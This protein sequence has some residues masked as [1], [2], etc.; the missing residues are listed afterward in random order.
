MTVTDNRRRRR[1]CTDGIDTLWNIEQLSFCDVPGAVRGTCDLRAAPVLVSSLPVVGPT[2]SASAASLTFASQA[3]TTTS[4]T[5][6]ITLTNTGTANLVVS[7][8][9][10]TGTD[11]A[12]F[13]VA[14]TTCA[15]IVINASCG[16]DVT[17]TPATIGAKTASLSI[18]SNAVGSPLIV[19]LTGTGAAAAPIA[20]V[21]PAS[22]TFGTQ[23]VGT[24]SAAQTITVSNTG[25]A[26]LL[27]SGVTLGGT[28]ANQ[29]ATTNGCA[30]PVA[31]AASCTI[32]VTF[33]PTSAGAK[34][35]SVSI[36]H[37]A[38]GSPS[39]VTLG[40]TGSAS[41][42]AATV[43]PASL[44]FAS[45]NVGTVSATQAITV[46]NTGSANLVVTGAT[47][48]GADAGQFAIASTTCATVVPAASC[49]VNVRFAPTTAGAKTASVSIAHNAAGS[50]SLVGVSG[51]AVTATTTFSVPATLAFGNRKVNN[52]TTN[53]L[54][55][56]NT[57]P[58]PLIISSASTA[59]PFSV[60]LGTCSAAVAVGRTCRLSV[61]FRATA[62]GPF[63]G[64]LTV[65]SSNAVNSPLVVALTGTG[66]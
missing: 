22:L 52:P 57:G 4:A 30:A 2:A 10:V 15:T 47:L 23:G 55:V 48:T 49:V 51:T 61:T 46:T 14:G 33:T 19:G 62:V 9:T 40:G 36:A 27:V 17:F 11:A 63:S 32:G 60:T 7:G 29:F 6:T 64:T 35:A 43:S 18:A 34:S 44:T 54:T 65:V 12:L 13:A 16:I 28:N 50:P 3:I 20:A 1:R 26:N 53:T 45:R 59:A 31:P 66:R 42:P 25:T 39:A 8:I 21:A 56:T 24:T 37:N 41:A 38:A 5:Q 58:N